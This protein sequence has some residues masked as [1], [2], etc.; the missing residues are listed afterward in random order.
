MTEKEIIKRLTELRSLAQKHKLD[1][2]EEIKQLEAKLVNGNSSQDATWKKVELARHNDRPTTLDYIDI[3]FDDFL[4]LHG[5]RSFSDDP[6]M[7][8]G[9]ALL[10]DKPVTIIGQQK[11]RNLKEN[12]MR[13]S[14]MALP[15]GYRKALRLVRQAEKYGRPVISFVDTQGAYPGVSAEERGIG[16]AIARNLKEFFSVRVPIVVIIIG[17]GGSGGALGIGIG[18]YVIMLENAIYSVISPEG[19]ASILL[20]DASKAKYAASIMKLTARDLLRFEIIDTIISEP[21]GGAHQNPEVTAAKIKLELVKVLNKLI[22]RPQEQLVKNRYEKYRR[23]GVFIE[24]NA[25]KKS[26]FLKR[27]LRKE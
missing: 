18:D 17:Q 10:N 13:N 1:I 8:G 11:G 12:V 24:K 5:D 15:D 4:E 7:I 26:G 25:K 16:E 2:S 22:S 19:C 9:I 27:F 21:T 23:M 14:G 6:A 20:R 3:I